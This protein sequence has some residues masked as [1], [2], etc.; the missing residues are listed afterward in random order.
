M[1]YEGEE[2]EKSGID[3]R[4]L[5][6]SDSTAQVEETL[7]KVP[8]ST[9][10]TIAHNNDLESLKSVPIVDA[11][12]NSITSKD[13][14]EKYRLIALNT[15]DLIAFT[16]FDINP[17]YTFISPSHKKL[18][19]YEAEDLLGKHGLNFIH[20]DDKQTMITLLLS[21]FDAKLHGTVPT[22]MTDKAS[23]LEYR[24]IDKFGQW[25][26]LRSTVDLV[27][28][29]LL[30]ISK[31]MTEQKK[32]EE[33][34]RKSEEK[35]RLVTENAS[36]VIWTMDMNLRF[37]YVSPSNVKITGYTNE[38][39]MELSIDKLFTPE[40]LELAMQTYAAEMELENSEKR[41]LNRARTIE[42][43]EI[44]A[45][46]TIIQI[47]VRMCFLRDADTKPIGILGITREITER[48]KQQDAL[49]KSE[50]KFVKAFKGSPVAIAIT[51]LADGKFIEMNESFQKFFGYSRE[52]LFVRTTVEAGLWFD[53]KDR[54]YVVKELSETGSVHDCELR[55][56]TK[57][58]VIKV[59][60]CSAEIMDIGD[61]RCFI[62]VLIDVT[63]QKK[64][65]ES[66]QESEAKYRSIVENT[67]DVVML[68]L[69]DGTVSYLSPAC[70]EVLG[71]EP[72]ELVGKVP[73]I[74]YLRDIDRI[75]AALSTAL[76]GK[77]G[78]NFE[79]RI[80]TKKGEVKWVCHSWS[81]IYMENHQLKYIVSV[82]RDISES[83]I[84]EQNLKEKI[85]ELER[86]KIVTVDREVKMVE[87][88]NEIHE[89]RKELAQKQNSPIVDG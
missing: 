58:G 73:E 43:N 24:I 48:K 62:S 3:P 86:Y 30:F 25:H 47:E 76:Q 69:P 5:H 79:Y 89:L 68:T 61:E 38:Q 83:K 31:D 6:A 32:A 11:E 88:K 71:Y 67:K 12:K 53:I 1:S 7:Q 34:L 14:T 84:F 63:E 56:C 8:E 41:D 64:I 23:R 78:T 22:D 19:G 50:E 39:M 49:K 44:K 59:A 10:D 36:D 29:E 55:F 82:V 17:I 81:P 80:I 9:P 37:T 72:N 54:E 28:D 57:G 27:N 51:R 70:T 26:F 18:L 52:E 46:G 2:G 21:Y 16:T 74:Y 87:L 20:N 85:V 15:S 45:D 77:S 40:S 13:L 66:L 35:Y 42:L 4:V 65:K 33:L 75:H 60:L